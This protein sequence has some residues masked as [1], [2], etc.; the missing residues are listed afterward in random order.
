M[1]DKLEIFISKLHLILNKEEMRILPGN[2]AFFFVFAIIPIVTL[3]VFFGSF[4]KFETV[5]LVD[6]FNN[7]FPSD[8][9]NILVPAFTDETIKLST[10]VLLIV[11]LYIASNGAHSIIIAS[12]RLYRVSNNNSIKR[13]IKAIFMILL[14]ILLLIF[15]FLVPIFGDYIMA[16]L[17]SMASNNLYTT[18]N[19]IYKILKFPLSLLFVYFILKLVYTIAPDKQLKSVEVTKGSIF[20]TISWVLT[21]SVYSYYISNFA[22]Y[23]KVY[24]NLSNI[25]ILMFYIYILAFIFVIGMAFNALNIEL[26]EEIYK[27]GKITNLKKW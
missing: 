1:I 18:F 26:D 17:K 4:F 19:V 23:S 13:R 20:T 21:S 24:G 25:I 27:T 9:G 6:F 14:I 7:Y 11:S 3:F 5:Q 15:M 10:I 8:I 2:L 22:N 16:S 12:N